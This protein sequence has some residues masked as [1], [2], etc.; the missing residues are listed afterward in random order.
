M[1]YSVQLD[2]LVDGEK[3]T[4]KADATVTPAFGEL[5]KPR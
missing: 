1:F 2:R 5:V 4:V 3:N